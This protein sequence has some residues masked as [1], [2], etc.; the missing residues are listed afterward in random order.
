M[1]WVLLLYCEP[2][3]GGEI[4]PSHKAFL[5]YCQLRGNTRLTGLPY[6]VQHFSCSTSNVPNDLLGLRNLSFIQIGVLVQ[7]LLL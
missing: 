6:T 7:H 2:Y 1:I 5:T 3:Y 4:A